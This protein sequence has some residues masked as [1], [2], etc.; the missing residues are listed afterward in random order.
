[1]D[2]DYQEIYKYPNN[3]EKYPDNIYP[4]EVKQVENKKYTMY[5]ARFNSLY[6]L[7]DY[8]KSEPEL[9]RC[10]F[11]VLHSVHNESYFAGKP[12]KEA[13]EHL[14]DETDSGYKEFL[15][16]QKDINNARTMDVHKYKLVRTVAGGHLNIPLYSAGV[17]LCYE[18][19]EKIRK[20][21]FVRIH[22]T[23]SY[24]C[25]TTKDQV[26]HRAVI[27]TNI[28][29]A[30][31]R[32]GYNVELNTFELSKEDDELIYIII[33]IKKYGQKINM[34]ALYKTLC[35]VE[36]LRRIMFRIL[37]SLDVKRDWGDGYG[38]TTSEQFTRKALNLNEFDIFFDQPSEMGIKGK[39]LAEDFERAI[40]HLS[41]EDKIDVDKAKKEF[42][43]SVLTLRRKNK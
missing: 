40:K 9:N 11:R 42:N 31:E 23:L 17:P 30:L 27:I 8:L 14:V 41:L 20:P 5:M 25:G 19:E 10:V 1:M 12:Y 35:N 24:Y 2:R 4:P 16:L 13:L 15:K 29:K 39:N 37:E 38:Q 21:R 3:Y 34:S 7:Y 6:S 26:L 36:F 32:A 22:V 33:A 18:T 43:E 28:I